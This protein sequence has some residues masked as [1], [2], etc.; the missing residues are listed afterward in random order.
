MFQTQLMSEGREQSKVPTQRLVRFT[1]GER[2]RDKRVHA[3][4]TEEGKAQELV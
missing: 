4:H 3:T 2:G 1:W